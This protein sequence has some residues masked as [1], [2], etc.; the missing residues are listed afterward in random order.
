MFTGIV[1]HVG[2]LERVVRRSGGARLRVAA[3]YEGLALGE[4]V[5]V[6]GVCLTVV[7]REAGRFEADASAE[8]LARS[9]LGAAATGA[10]VNLERALQVG[11]RLGGH[12]VTGHVD[13]V[14]RLL[15]REALG[16]S[17]RLRVSL[18]RE[19]APL[20]AP[21]GSIALDGV[22]LT[23]NQVS[24]TWF[25][26]VVVPFTLRATTLAALLPGGALNLEVDVL[27]KYVARALSLG[28]TASPTGTAEPARD[29]VTLE[30]LRRSGYL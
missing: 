4:S 27:A 1:E 13:A 25:E 21:K 6:S 12:L 29:G 2:K 23:V 10:A 15:D 9:T 5:S 19:L 8:T 24:D 7:E 11:A 26:V 18:P 30:V 17:E 16:D 20:V 28:A 3:P 22:S 14:G